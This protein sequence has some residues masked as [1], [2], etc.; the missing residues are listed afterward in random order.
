MDSSASQQQYG[1]APIHL[2]KRL[3]WINGPPA[4]VVARAIFPRPST[5][6]DSFSLVL[7][8]NEKQYLRDEE[9]IE[10]YEN[11]ENKR[12]FSREIVD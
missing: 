12:R 9:N 3:N 4:G 1:I 2:I 6:Q 7:P 8:T 5:S 10:N 11:E